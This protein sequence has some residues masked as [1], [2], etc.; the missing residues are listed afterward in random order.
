[1]FGSARRLND[2]LHD[3][4]KRALDELAGIDADVILAENADVLVA[5]LL[6]K[7]MPAEIKIDWDGAT[8]TPV[9]EVTTQVRDQFHRDESYTVPASKVVVSVPI[10]GTTEMLD[11]QASHFSLSGSYGKVS[12]GRVTI[13]ILERTL[14]SEDVRAQVERVKQDVERRTGW[15][16]GDLAAFRKTA[17]QS[18]RTNFEG[19]SELRV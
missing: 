2:Y 9:T 13:E 10:T 7:Y 4:L 11:Y 5:S 6:G 12:G 17:E 18:I 1:M 16:N 8:R 3:R 14:N 15:A 19:S